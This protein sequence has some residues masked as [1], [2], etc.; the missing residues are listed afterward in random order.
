MRC[1]KCEHQNVAEKR[2]GEEE[3]KIRPKHEAM[4]NFNVKLSVEIS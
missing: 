2:K 3:Q 4:T 1:R